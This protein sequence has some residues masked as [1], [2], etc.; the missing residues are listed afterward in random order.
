MPSQKNIQKVQE[1]TDLLTKSKA[2]IL[3]DYTGLSVKDQSQLRKQIKEAG[4]QFTVAKNLLFKLALSQIKKKDLPRDVEDVLQGPTAF[5]FAFDDKI[6]PIKALIQFS[7]EHE[8]PK[9]K[10]GLILEPKD[11]VLSIEEIEQLARLPT[12]DQLIAQLIGT[13]NSPRTRLINTLS[14]NL[15]KLTLVLSEIKNQKESN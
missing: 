13:L 11:R 5:L 9:T 12:H 4:G 3:A 6:A 2:V 8:L 14:Q 10:I 1:L 7:Q 15:S